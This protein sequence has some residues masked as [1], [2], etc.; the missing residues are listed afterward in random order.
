[1]LN[2]VNP[3]QSQILPTFLPT[4]F[5]VHSYWGTAGHHISL[6][7]IYI[8]QTLP[9][10]FSNVVFFVRVCVEQQQSVSAM[11]RLKKLLLFLRACV[12]KHTPIADD[13]NRLR[14]VVF[15]LLRHVLPRTI[16]DQDPSPRAV[17]DD[18]EV[19]RDLVGV[20]IHPISF[21]K[22]LTAFTDS[23]RTINKYE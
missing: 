11:L 7:L 22:L 20:H 12:S 1:M 9:P 6:A 3:P 18:D 21:V 10:F 19:V 2:V 16:G 15:R 5:R 17:V 23:L 4:F 8:S 13:A 14:Y